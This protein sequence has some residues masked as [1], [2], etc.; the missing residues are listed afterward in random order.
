MKAIFPGSFDPVT[1]GHADVIRR[2]ARLADEL[3]VA[4][5]V[6]PDKKT[7]FTTQER[8]EMLAAACAEWKNVRVVS[9]A[10]LLADLARREGATLI[11][12]GVRGV[13]EFEAETA[14]AQA[15]S[16]LLPGLETALLPAAAGLASVS[17]SLVRQI[18]AFG[19]DVAPFVPPAAA[20][21]IRVKYSR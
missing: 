4:V 18:A 21:A 2:A 17:S 19:G 12:R 1:L 8:V 13:A 10:G 11:V 9:F 3:I 20:G 5:L 6:N 15:N 14:M 7:M 16:L